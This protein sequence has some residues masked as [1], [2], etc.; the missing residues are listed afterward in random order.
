MRI[1]AT[2]PGAHLMSHPK[3]EISIAPT[4]LQKKTLL[5][6]H[7]SPEYWSKARMQLKTSAMAAL[8]CW[9]AL[10][11]RQRQQQLAEQH[12]FKRRV[13]A[14][15]ICRITPRNDL[16]KGV[17]YFLRGLDI[18]IELENYGYKKPRLSYLGAMGRDPSLT[19]LELQPV[20]KMKT[21]R[22][23]TTYVSGSVA[24]ITWNRDEPPQLSCAQQQKYN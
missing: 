16:S 10:C 5:E 9:S 19:G 6:S 1:Q 18:M 14:K 21:T 24:Y 7:E 22:L 12:H 15:D 23:L 17:K 20:A 2:L 13:L 3:G 4:S 11:G 8:L